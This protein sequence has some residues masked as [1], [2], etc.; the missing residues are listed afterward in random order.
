MTNVIAIS[1]NRDSSRFDRVRHI[2]HINSADNKV[3]RDEHRVK[4]NIITRHTERREKE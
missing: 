2:A 3:T 4:L 1:K